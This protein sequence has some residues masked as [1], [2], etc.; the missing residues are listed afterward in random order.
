[1]TRLTCS[2]CGCATYI[3]GQVSDVTC[4]MCAHEVNWSDLLANLEWEEAL[5][6]DDDG[7]LCVS[8]IGD[9]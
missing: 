8:N 3:R 9:V 5:V 1:M 4:E 7:Y 2:D 6:F